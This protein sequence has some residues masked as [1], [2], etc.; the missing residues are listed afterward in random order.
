MLKI[1]DFVEK[2]NKLDTSKISALTHIISLGNV[3]RE[4]KVLP[5][6]SQKEVLDLAPK[7]EGSFIKVPKII[8]KK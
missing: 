7:K 5:S 1:L 4:D 3:F 2:L 8:E 6:L